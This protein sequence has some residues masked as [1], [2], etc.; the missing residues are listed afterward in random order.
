MKKLPTWCDEAAYAHWT[1]DAPRL[2]DWPEAYEQLLQAPKLSRVL[3][4]S[5]AHLRSQFREPNFNSRFRLDCT[6]QR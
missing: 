3:H 5:E 2:P 1:E 4:P 6:A